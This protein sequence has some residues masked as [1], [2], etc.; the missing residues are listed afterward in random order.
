MVV[1]EVQP[2]AATGPVTSWPVVD[3]TAIRFVRRAIADVARA[4]HGSSNHHKA[5]DPHRVPVM[6]QVEERLM[7]VGSELISNALRHASQPITAAL[8]RCADGWVVVVDDG[9]SPGRPHVAE[10]RPTGGHGLRLV[11]LLSRAIG[12]HT[13]TRGHQVWAEVPDEAP[14]PLLDKLATL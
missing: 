14:N 3:P 7:L 9:G 12:W 4:D 2:P 6:A 1:I 5:A 10:A 11:A 13:T 8:Y